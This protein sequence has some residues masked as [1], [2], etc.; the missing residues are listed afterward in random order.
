[1]AEKRLFLIQSHLS[2]RF[3]T[4]IKTSL[5]AYRLNSAGLNQMIL[6]E[7]YLG[8]AHSMLKELREVMKDNSLLNHNESLFLD[9]S[10]KYSLIFN[11]ALQFVFKT[12]VN[13]EADMQDPTYKIHVTQILTEFEL[14]LSTRYGVSMG[15]YVDT[16]Q[17]IGTKK[18]EYL[19][20]LAYSFKNFGCFALTELGHGSNVSRLE[21]TAHFDNST[22]EFVFN[23]PTNTSAKWWIGAAAKTANMA[24]VWAQLYIGSECKGVHV[25]VVEIRDLESHEVKPGITIGDCGK[26]LELDAVDNGFIIFTNFR[27][28]YDSL[29]DY[30]SQISAEGKFK[31]SIKNNDKRMGIMMGGLLRGR[32]IVV[33]SSEILLRNALTIALRYSAVRKQFGLADQPEYTILDYQTHR[34]RLIPHLSKMFAIRSGLLCIYSSF[35][36]VYPTVRENHDSED[37][38]EFHAI[39]SAMKTAS[40][41]YSFAGIQECREACGGVGYSAHSGIGRLRNTCDV[42]LTWEGDNTILVQQTGKYILKQLQK[43]FKGVASESKTLQFLKINSEQMPWPIKTVENISIENFLKIAENRICYLAGETIK[44][45]Q[46][47]AGNY[48]SHMEIW[49][50][51]QVNYVNLLTKTYIEYIMLVE[52][53]KLV[54]KISSRCAVTGK[55]IGKLCELYAID[56]LERNQR[57]YLEMGC[58]LQESL[59]LRDRHTQL[60]DEI[61]ESS[62]TVIDSIASTD[63]FL[64]SVIGHS[65]GDVYRRMIDA[66]EAEKDVYS[67][68][69]WYKIVHDARKIKP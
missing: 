1:M 34:C 65:D 30:Y 19:R 67:R 14:A 31:T 8:P 15:L 42:L 23:S 59:M 44:K 26:K 11:Q 24:V 56:C 35:S 61:G 2:S 12:H 28:G 9:R 46:E 7:E 51:T 36:A 54:S 39:L 69:E 58:T 60:C 47:N 45:M 27:A 55:I 21:T 66:V 48:S 50:K 3:P 43:G 68:A 64:G 32:I 29:L 37:L 40:S 57:C 4:P 41:S 20:D 53:N 5:E 25:F 10:S 16:V 18:H 33:Q 22:R 49:N 6:S 62:V 17:N 13:Y 38:A 63:S 52:F